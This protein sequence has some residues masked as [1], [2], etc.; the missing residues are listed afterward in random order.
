MGYVGPETMF[1]LSLSPEGRDTLTDL[2]EDALE[3]RLTG[4]TTEEI[5]DRLNSDLA[6][7]ESTT[8]TPQM[9]RKIVLGKIPLPEPLND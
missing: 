4:L 5:E 2:I 8:P 3:L 9:V 6:R 7:L 1:V